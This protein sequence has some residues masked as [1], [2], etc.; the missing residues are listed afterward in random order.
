MDAHRWQW[1]RL[2]PARDQDYPKLLNAGK[3][4]SRQLSLRTDQVR[5]GDTFQVRDPEWVRPLEFGAGLDIAI[6]I[7]RISGSSKARSA[8]TTARYAV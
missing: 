1:I 7:D 4:C 8:I 5:V 2:G 3:G 6:A